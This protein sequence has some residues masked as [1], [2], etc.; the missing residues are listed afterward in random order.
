MT[1]LV[2]IMLKKA[3]PHVSN[4]TKL[5]NYIFSQFFVVSFWSLDFILILK[6]ETWRLPFFW[7]TSH[8]NTIY[9]KIHL[10]FPHSE[11]LLLLDFDLNGLTN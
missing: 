10:A 1:S 4:I 5:F 11:M 8:P 2:H 6:D 3:Y 9:W 7:L